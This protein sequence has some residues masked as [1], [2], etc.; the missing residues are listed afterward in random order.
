[1]QRRDFLKT[2][3]CGAPLLAVG[4]YLGQPSRKSDNVLAGA[5]PLVLARRV[6]AA[7]QAG[8]AG[9][10][11]YQSDTGVQLPGF[12][13]LLPRFQK[14]VRPGRVSGRKMRARCAHLRRT[15]CQ[16]VLLWLRPAAALGELR[17]DACK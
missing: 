3:A 13:R 1:M 5:N 12:R 10:V 8:L 14:Q 17:P 11:F 6:L 7:H 4:Q 9:V 2:T 15:D 16:S